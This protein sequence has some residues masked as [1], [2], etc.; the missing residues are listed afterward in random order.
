MMEEIFVEW[1]LE[2]MIF[3]YIRGKGFYKVNRSNPDRYYSTRE[4]YDYW[5]T[6]IL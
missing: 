6:E 3:I 5:K 1:L 2:Q 4:V